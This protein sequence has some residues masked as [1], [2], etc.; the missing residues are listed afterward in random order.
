MEFTKISYEEM[1]HITQSPQFIGIMLFI[2]LIIGLILYLIIAGS[3]RA[4]TPNGVKLKSSML[5]HGNAWIPVIIWLVQ[6]GFI[7]I[8]LIFPFWAKW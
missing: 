5:S 4:R 1:I 8:L 2:W 7:L 3:I 6:G